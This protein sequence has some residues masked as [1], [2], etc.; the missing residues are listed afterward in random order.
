[1]TNNVTSHKNARGKEGQT[2]HRVFSLRL[3]TE[4]IATTH[5]THKHGP[6]H[7][8][9]WNQILPRGKN[10]AMAV[11]M[12]TSQA[13]RPKNMSRFLRMYP[14]TRNFPFNF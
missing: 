14:P 11:D 6:I 5:K 2:H 10:D 13:A 7:S 9:Q 12:P 1:M 4:Y 3:L 8:S